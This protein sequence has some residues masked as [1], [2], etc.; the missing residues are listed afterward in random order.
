MQGITD[1]TAFAAVFVHQQLR[2]STWLLKDPDDHL[3][4]L[5]CCCY[6]AGHVTLPAAAAEAPTALAAATLQLHP[7]K[8]QQL[9]AAA[10]A[11]F[12]GVQAPCKSPWPMISLHALCGQWHCCLGIGEV[13][14]AS[15]GTCITLS[16]TGHGID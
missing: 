16:N 12:K 5:R 14:L 10:A 11:A 6:P 13:F 15:V 8:Q 4:L 3:C 9:A 2:K 7:Y 1:Q